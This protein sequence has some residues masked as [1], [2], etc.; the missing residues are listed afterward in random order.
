M[1][2]AHLCF[3]LAPIGQAC[4][5]ES[6]SNTTRHLD[7]HAGCELDKNGNPYCSRRGLG[8]DFIRR[9]I[10]SAEVAKWVVENTEFDQLYFYDEAKPVHVS[11]GPDNKRQITWMRNHLMPHAVTARYFDEV[12][13]RPRTD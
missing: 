4:S 5:Q 12:L 3:R 7:Q 9:G 8:V 10:N 11:V 13:S 2:R 6:S 1:R